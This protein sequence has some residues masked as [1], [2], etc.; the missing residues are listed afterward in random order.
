METNRESR[1]V[2]DLQEI[3]WEIWK[4][5][6][7]II[8]SG[9]LLALLVGIFTTI[10]IQ[11]QYRA[12]TKIYISLKEDTEVMSNADLQVGSSLTKDYAEI[13]TSYQVL[14]AVIEKLNLSVSYNALVNQVSVNIPSDTR[15][16]EVS[17]VDSEAVRAAQIADAVREE[18][19]VCIQTIMD[20]PSVKVVD[21][22]RVPDQAVSPSLKK[23]VGLGF[24][25]G[26]VISIC[27]LVAVWLLNDKMQKN[28]DVERYL[29]A[30][31]LGRIP[32]YDTQ[33]A[34]GGKKKKK[35]GKRNH[36]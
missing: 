4:K 14:E 9:L 33:A 34:R 2:L 18:S 19:M 25:A 7:W 27:V 13:V 10:F 1:G 24:L 3:L 20:I 28:E 5:K 6:I 11:P 29:G 16:V 15:M 23:N 26:I 32:Q 35:H 8:I 31:V 21:E 17:V 12:S 36:N 22:A 30:S